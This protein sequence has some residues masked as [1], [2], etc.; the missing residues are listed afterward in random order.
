M[1]D[2]NIRNIDLIRTISLVALLA[3]G[4]SIHAIAGERASSASA[5]TVATHS[6]QLTVAANV[7]QVRKLLLSQ[8]YTNVSELSRDANGRWT[9]TA[10]K[11]GQKKI[12]SVALPTSRTA[13][14]AAN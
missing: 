4:S 13:A 3:A 9:G 2:F 14:S 12:V 10:T 8:G 6:A 11:N 7:E 1:R 5:D